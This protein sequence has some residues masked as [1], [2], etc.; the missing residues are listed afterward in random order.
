MAEVQDGGA[1]EPRWSAD[2]EVPVPPSPEQ[3]GRER[4]GL[5]EEWEDWQASLLQLTPP[6]RFEQEFGLPW[7]PEPEPEPLSGM[8]ST[9][10]VAAFT[11]QAAVQVATVFAIAE[12]HRITA[13]LTAYERAMEDLEVR[14]DRRIGSR[15]GLGAQAFFTSMGLQLKAHPRRIAHEV[16]AALLL[17][18]RL[19]KTWE[20]F[21]HGNTAWARAALAASNAEGLDPQHWAAFDEAA[22][23]LVVTSH[24]LKHDLRV[25]REKLQADTAA[26]RARTTH[27]RRT[28][29]LELGHDGEASLVIT[30]PAAALVAHNDAL[31]RAAVAAHGVPGETRT[32]A[33]LRH[34]IALDL[35][36]EGLHRQADPA[37]TTVRV[38]E[39]KKVDVQLILTVPALGWLGRTT[40]H[41]ILDGYG[42]IAMEVAKDLAGDAKSFIRVLT[43]PVTGVRLTMDRQVYSPPADLA[44]WVKIRDGRSRF[45]GS[46]RPAHLSDIDHAREWQHSGTTGF[47]NLVTLDRPAHNMKSAKLYQ[48]QLHDSGIVGWNDAWDHYFE[49]PPAD[50]L[51]PAPPRL[52]PPEREGPDEPCPF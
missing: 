1:G 24:R 25:K 22:A 39:R 19:P 32:L 43:D 52:M 18:D 49:D 48:E 20:V 7:V 8:V 29:S 16:D 28:T 5:K 46:T 38:P 51:D 12:A 10:E 15:G 33:M 13:V 6:D 35:L 27:E 31:H 50:P 41:A 34:D 17:R 26:A 44:R 2:G 45:P 23:R 40:E 3:A 47:S 36:D 21:Q 37:C 42:P 30:G 11:Q 14:F 9:E 4:A